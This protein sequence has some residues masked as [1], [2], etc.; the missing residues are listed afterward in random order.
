MLKIVLLNFIFLLFGIVLSVVMLAFIYCFKCNS[1]IE[2]TFLGKITKIKNKRKK[3]IIS[4]NVNDELSINNCYITNSTL[5]KEKYLRST[6]I[7]ELSN[8]LK[9]QKK[10][11]ITVDGGFNVKIIEIIDTNI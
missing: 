11:K 8:L 3:I 1:K 5:L 2:R 7:E 10:Y 6:S 4:V 9:E